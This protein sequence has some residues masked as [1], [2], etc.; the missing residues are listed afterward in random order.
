MK[1]WIT[2]LLVTLVVAVPAFVLG[3][4]LFPPAE[5]GIEPTAGQIPYFVLLAAWA[6][7]FVGLGVAFLLFGMPVLR[8]VSP[9]SSVRAWVMYL[10]IGFLTVSWWPPLNMYASNGIDFQGL[11]YPGYGFHVPLMISAAALIYCFISIARGRMKDKPA[12]TVVRGP[13][14]GAPLTE[15]QAK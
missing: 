5:V 6:A 12:Y 1:P 13:G 4:V 7:V 14:N 10:S 15:S 3:P 9:D 11:L 2:V 8:K